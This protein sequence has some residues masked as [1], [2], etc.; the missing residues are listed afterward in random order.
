M[1]RDSLLV[2]LVKL[3]DQIPV[4]PP[5][6]KRSRGCPRFYPDRL[7]L[8]ALRFPKASEQAGSR[9]TLFQLGALGR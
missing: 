6:A 3:V 2:E 8:K 9:R 5:P 4:P 1:I 7:F